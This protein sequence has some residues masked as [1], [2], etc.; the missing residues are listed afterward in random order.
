MRNIST[1]GK[2]T[3]EN[4][5]RIIVLGFKHIKIYVSYI[6]IYIY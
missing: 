1:L 6:Y 3:R 5:Q 2:N 4:N